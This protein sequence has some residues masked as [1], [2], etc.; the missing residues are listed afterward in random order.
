MVLKQEVAFNIQT[1]RR[2]GHFE[3]SKQTFRGL[4]VSRNVDFYCSLNDLMWEREREW[5]RREKRR[6]KRRRRG[7]GRVFARECLGSPYLK[8]ERI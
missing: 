2:S 5:E 1:A 3:A 6:G 7:R 4:C 8:I